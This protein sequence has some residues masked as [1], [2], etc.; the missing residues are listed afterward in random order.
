[1]KKQ[2]KKKKDFEHKEDPIWANGKYKLRHVILQL[3]HY[4]PSCTT[5]YL[6]R[7]KGWFKYYYHG[8]YWPKAQKLHQMWGPEPHKTSRQLCSGH[9]R[10]LKARKS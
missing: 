10:A 2:K 7:T 5:S 8:I 1:M 4:H 9:R 6:L 3:F